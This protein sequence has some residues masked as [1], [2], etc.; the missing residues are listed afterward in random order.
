MK[1]LIGLLVIA[2]VFG[3]SLPVAAQPDDQYR[4]GWSDAQ[5]GFQDPPRRST[6]NKDSDRDFHRQQE[7]NYGYDSGQQYR[8]FQEQ[9]DRRWNQER[10]QR[11]NQ[12]DERE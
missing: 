4:K 10:R 5:T 7:Y 8:E 1:K 6:D 2:L 11:M 9:D 12:D 3:V